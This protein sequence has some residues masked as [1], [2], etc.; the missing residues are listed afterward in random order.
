[1]LKALKTKPKTR[2]ESPAEQ[3]SDF[4]GARVVNTGTVNVFLISGEYGELL[5]DWINNVAL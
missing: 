2:S 3:S 5:I 1:M 4:C